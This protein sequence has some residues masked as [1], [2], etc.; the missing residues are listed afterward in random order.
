M[1][2]R[3]RFILGGVAAGLGGLV[4]AYRHFFSAPGAP[5]SRPAERVVFETV[6]TDGLAHLPYLIGVPIEK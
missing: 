2:T 3:R 4:L 1:F 5:A 6:R